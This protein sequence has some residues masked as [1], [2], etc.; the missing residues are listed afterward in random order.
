MFRYTAIVLAAVI[1]FLVS[2]D[3]VNAHK[4]K[5]RVFDISMNLVEYKGSTTIDK[6]APPDIDPRDLSKGYGYK[7]PGYDPNNPGKWEVS[8]YAFNP[9]FMTIHKGD[10]VNLTVFGVNGDEHEVILV[11]PNGEELYREIW[12]RGREYHISFKAKMAGI[13][14]L[15]C[16]HHFPTMKAIFSVE[17]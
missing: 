15:I 10:Q 8:S 7:A 3:T 17:K 11:D 12:N 5:P 4:G 2:S 14:E 6:L 16:L 9:S 13:Y 1:F